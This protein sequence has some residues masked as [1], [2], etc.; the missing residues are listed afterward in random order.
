MRALNTDL[1]L[2]AEKVLEKLVSRSN[3][4][5]ETGFNRRKFMQ[6]TALAGAGASL[7]SATAAQ[8][9]Q[10][11]GTGGPTRFNE[12]TIAELQAAMAAR[13]VSSVELTTFYLN[14]ILAIDQ[15]GPGLNS[16]IEINPDALAIAKAADG[17]RRQGTVL[18]PMH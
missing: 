16:I 18:A 4:L 7:M 15:R 14:R 3:D 6:L 2:K 11:Q 1:R 8:A 10:P 9:A 17:L 13:K 12:A 5:Q